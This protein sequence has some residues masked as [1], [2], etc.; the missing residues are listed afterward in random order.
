MQG[1]RSKRNTL[2]CNVTF[3][4]LSQAFRMP[5]LGVDALVERRSGPHSASGSLSIATITHAKMHLTTYFRSCTLNSCKRVS[6]FGPTEDRSRRFSLFYPLKLLFILNCT[7]RVKL[8]GDCSTPVAPAKLC[9]LDRH[10]SVE[11][12]FGVYLPLVAETIRLSIVNNLGIA[13][14]M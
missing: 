9:Q 8:L 1:D 13:A 4:K 6:A 14:A 7:N 12:S 2:I 11:F 5:Q 3:L 10:P